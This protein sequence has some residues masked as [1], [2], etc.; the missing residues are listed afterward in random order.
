[1]KK[2]VIYDGDMGGDD[3]WALATLL[4]HRDKFNIL[5]IA[6][7]FGNVSQPYATQNVLNFLNW[8][9]VDDI[10]VMQGADQPLDGMRPFGD[11]AYG[12]DGVGGVI[13]PE[14]PKKP[15]TG[16]IADLYAVLLNQRDKDVTVLATGPATNLAMFVEKYPDNANNISEI[17]FM[18]GGLNPPGKDGKPVYLENGTQRIGNI[19]PY[20]EF[21][22]FQDPKALNVLLKSGIPITFM[23]TDASQF[24]VLT[25]ERQQRIVDIH[26][27]YGPALHKMLMVVA[28]LDMTKYDVEGPFIHDPNVSAYM[29]RPD[30]YVSKPVPNLIFDES[31]P[32]DDDTKRGMASLTGQFTANAKWLCGV[33]DADAVYQ[34]IEDGLRETIARSAGS[35]KPPAI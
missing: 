32:Q 28:D 30:L 5:G 14:S 11:N 4:A 8:L 12:S 22:A 26:P 21:N 20:A 17:I 27:T 7:V 35:P 31:S 15:V 6:S 24:L 23:A 33:K 34:V 19:T 3:L 13:L 9:K 29:V 1:M 25:P 18:G 16:N 10:M 2:R